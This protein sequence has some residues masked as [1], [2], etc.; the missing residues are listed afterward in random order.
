[1]AKHDQSLM[2]RVAIER[3]PKK[4]RELFLSQF[5]EEGRD[6]YIDRMDKNAFNSQF[7][8][9]QHYFSASLPETAVGMVSIYTLNVH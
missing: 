5:T 3:L 8:K 7:G 6:P 9:S 1:M 4:T 2:L